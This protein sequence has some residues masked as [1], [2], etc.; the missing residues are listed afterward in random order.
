AFKVVEELRDRLPGL[1]LSIGSPAA[2]FKAQM[3]RADK[4][5]ARYALILGDAEVAADRIGVK[6]LREERPQ[7]LMTLEECTRLL[8]AAPLGIE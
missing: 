5:G 2:G 8:G 3:R 4:S 1:R 7:E 6:P